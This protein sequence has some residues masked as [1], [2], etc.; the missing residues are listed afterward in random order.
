MGGSRVTARAP[1]SQVGCLL[2]S[3]ETRVPRIHSVARPTTA[4]TPAPRPPARFQPPMAP[5]PMKNTNLNRSMT[6]ISQTP[7]VPAVSRFASAARPSQNDTTG[8]RLRSRLHCKVRRA[9]HGDYGERRFASLLPRKPPRS[10]VAGATI[11]NPAIADQNGGVVPFVSLTESIRLPI[12]TGAHAARPTIGQRFLAMNPTTKPATR[13]TAKVIAN[14]S[15]TDSSGP[16]SE[17]TSGSTPRP[18]RSAARTA[19]NNLLQPND[20]AHRRQRSAAELPSECS[21][22]LDGHVPPLHSSIPTRPPRH[23]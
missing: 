20:Q 11:R 15:G 12:N 22:L 8:G 9:I 19:R 13:K 10:E 3:R 6:F 2:H 16:T 5:P 14:R 17:K 7:N 21:A 18:R 1:H 23:P 4:P